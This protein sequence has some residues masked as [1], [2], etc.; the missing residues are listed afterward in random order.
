MYPGSRPWSTCHHFFPAEPPLIHAPGVLGAHGPWAS[1]SYSVLCIHR[2]PCSSH[3]SSSSSQ[4]TSQHTNPTV[5]PTSSYLLTTRV[6]TKSRPF[7]S[8]PGL[9]VA[10]TRVFVLAGVQPGEFLDDKYCATAALVR[11]CRDHPHHKAAGATSG[12]R[13]R[14]V[15]R[16]RATASR[17][18]PTWRSFIATSALIQSAFWRLLPMSATSQWRQQWPR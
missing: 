2:L 10:E 13:T 16:C 4:T 7:R 9:F 6:F 11:S 8:V 5:C 17:H 3:I 14:S 18:P 12:T 1:P 15:E